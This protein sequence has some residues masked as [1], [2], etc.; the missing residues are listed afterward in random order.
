MRLHGSIVDVNRFFLVRR[1]TLL[2]NFLFR[3][4]PPRLNEV[5][6]YMS[7]AIISRRGSGGGSSGGGTLRT[8]VI[9]FTTN[10]VVPNHIG[11]ISEKIFGG[12]ASG[13]YSTGGAGGGRG[14]CGGWM[15]NSNLNL[16]N[17]STIPVT[18]GLGG[19][20]HY[21]IYNGS[22]SGGTTSFG[23]YLSAN[24]GSWNE[25]DLEVMDMVQMAV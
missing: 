17:G 19:N 12:G 7:E 11:D 10:W 22:V 13:G 9:A 3:Q 15:N 20:Q 23:S 16:S 4:H 5:L 8:E 14:G 25:G 18:I 1:N 24:G 6:K 2:T 21:I